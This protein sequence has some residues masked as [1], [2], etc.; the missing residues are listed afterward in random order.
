MAIKRIRKELA[1]LRKDPPTGCS[2]A[3]V[4]EDDMFMW[5]GTITGPPDSPYAGGTFTLN[6]RFPPDYPFN[7]PNIAFTTKMY[8]INILPT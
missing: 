2:A 7:P 3:P 5:Q 6:I 8:H 1:D 4:S